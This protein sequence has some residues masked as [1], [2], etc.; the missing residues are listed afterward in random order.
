[1]EFSAQETNKKVSSNQN[2]RFLQ[3]KHNSSSN[4]QTQPS[5]SIGLKSDPA[6]GEQN[7]IQVAETEL[8]KEGY[9]AISGILYQYVG[10][11]YEAQ[12]EIAQKRRIASYLNNYAEVVGDKLVYKRAN[13]Q[14][15]NQVYKW[16][17]A[18]RGVDSSLVNPSGLNCLNGV[19]KLEWTLG[20]EGY[21]E[22]Q[23]V[24]HKHKPSEIYTYVAGFAYE[25]NID[26][27]ECDRLLECLEPAFRD[28]LLKTLA[29]ALD[30]PTV[31]RYQGRN[32]R[33]ILMQGVGSNGKDALREVTRII[34]E[35]SMSSA[36]LTD[37]QQ[38]ERG[39]KFPLSKLAGKRVNWSSENANLT[40]LDNL[41]CLKAV[42]TGEGFDIE[43]KG[44]NETSTE[45]NLVLIFNCNEPPK[46]HGGLEAIESRYAVIPL[47]KV[48]KNNPQPERGE[49]KADARFRYDYEWVASQVAPAF[50]NKMLL[51][52]N[53]L[54]RNGID[55]A[56]C[57]EAIREVQEA[58]S[59]LWRFCREQRIGLVPGEKFYV[60]DLNQ[61]LEAWYLAE[62]IL[63]FGQGKKRIWQELPD[64]KPVKASNQIYARFKR[65]FPQ[66]RLQ[67]ETTDKTR[68]GQA[69]LLGIG[70]LPQ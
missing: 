27:G 49:L 20:E 19:I 10:T 16:V 53:D 57:Q 62:G 38:Y 42:I 50:F 52:L 63:E 29:A 41:Q 46:L 14:S 30:L 59:H 28:I 58:S 13:P 60:K 5:A 48:F 68:V 56:P 66:I 70:F 2:I 18:R 55:Y 67:R 21:P 64:D 39:R 15:V 26:G 51:A 69:Y 31:R 12:S 25:P 34:F 22:A 37:F 33:A 7:F 17:L 45:T 23:A 40:V 24:L 9:I 43:R 36:S 65:L 6:Q 61:T 3:P 32:I 35:N 8:Y 11:H 4:L 47:T 1:M 44:I 54:M